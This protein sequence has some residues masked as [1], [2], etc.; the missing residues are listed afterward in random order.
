MA[1]IQQWNL[2]NEEVTTLEIGDISDS[3]YL[4][5]EPYYDSKSKY[6]PGVRKVKNFHSHPRSRAAIYASALTSFS[7][8]PMPQFTNEDIAVGS[9]EGGCLKYPIVIASIYLDIEDK[10]VILPLM[11]ELIDFCST[12]NMKLICGIDCNAHSPLWGNGDLNKRGEVLEEFIFQK[13]LF[14]HNIG[15]EPTWQA[16]GLSSI[17]D[18]TVSLN[19]GDELMGWGVTKTTLSDHH[20]ISKKSPSCGPRTLWNQHLMTYMTLS[21]TG[22]TFHAPSVELRIGIHYYGGTMIVKM[23]NASSYP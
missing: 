15:N 4:L 16:R 3:I 7:F 17:I 9:I 11:A 14:V 22:L 8:V 12:R 6:R 13:G 19:L 18:I 5:Q 23:Q 1:K 21:I 2:H 10:Q 20:Q